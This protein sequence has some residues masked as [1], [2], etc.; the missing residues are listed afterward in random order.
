[1]HWVQAAHSP[2]CCCELTRLVPPPDLPAVQPHPAGDPGHHEAVS[3]QLGA[4]GSA[5]ERA[6]RRSWQQRNRWLE[7]LAVQSCRSTAC[8]QAGACMR[9]A[10]E[11]KRLSCLTNR[12]GLISLPCTHP[13]AYAPSPLPCRPPAATKT[14]KRAVD[15]SVTGAFFFYLTVSQMS[16]PFELHGIATTKP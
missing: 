13:T 3:G 14:M 9:G 12:H 11:G 1:M 15:I 16:V 10:V 4:A 7:Q 2:A 6:G 8:C 5:A